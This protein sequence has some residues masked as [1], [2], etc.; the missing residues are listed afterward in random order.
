[1]LY[2]LLT[3]IKAMTMMNDDDSEYTTKLHF[4]ISFH[5][6][7]SSRLCLT[8]W[9]RGQD[10]SCGTLWHFNKQTS[11]WQWQIQ[12]GVMQQSPP[13]AAKGNFFLSENDTNWKFYKWNILRDFRKFTIAR[14]PYSGRGFDP[15]PASLVELT[16]PPDPQLVGMGLITALPK[17]VSPLSAFQRSCFNL[18]ALSTQ[19][20]RFMQILNLSLHHDA[21]FQ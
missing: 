7:F 20:P 5:P 14:K 1:M 13:L 17:N 6:L 3:E 2:G 18:W 19:L 10:I 8:D 16:A 21:S 11:S 15:D 9:R 4:F 12:W